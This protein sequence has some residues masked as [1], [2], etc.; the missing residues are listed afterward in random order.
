MINGILP[1]RRWNSTYGVVREMGE[2]Q[3]MKPMVNELRALIKNRKL[4]EFIN[5]VKDLRESELLKD[6]GLKALYGLYLFFIQNH[7]KAAEILNELKDKEL[8][9]YTLA[10]L[11]LL[12]FFVGDYKLSKSLLH[13]ALKTKEVD[14]ATWARLANISYIEKDFDKAEYYW[15]RSLEINPDKLEVLYNLGVLKLNK[16]DFSEALNYFN[17]VLDRNP[18]YEEAEEK[19]TAALLNLNRIELIIDEYY[20]K[21]E[22]DKSEQN[23][24]KLGKVLHIAGRY[25]EARAVLIEAISKYKCDYRLKLLLVDVLEAEGAIGRAGNLLKEWVETQD[26]CDWDENVKATFRF[27]LNE[28]RVKAGFLDTAEQDIE[29]MKSKEDYPEYYLIKSDIL[30]E[31]NKGIEAKEILEKALEKF[32]AHLEILSKL[33]HILTSIGELDRAKDIQEQIVAI[34]PA[35]LVRQVEMN[36]YKATDEQIAILENMIYSKTLPKDSR[37]SAG[38]VLHTVLEKRKEYDK[39]FEVLIKANELVKED[40]DYN[41]KEHRFM[42]ERTI[43]VFTPDL[44]KKLYGKGH[45]SNRP[46]FV[47]GMPRSG[48]TLAEQILGSHSS[49][50]PAGELPFVGKIVSLMPKVVKSKRGWPDAML[51][52]DENLLKSAGQYYL[53]KIENLDNKHTRVVDKLPHNFDYIGLILLMFPN[54]KVIHLNRNDLDVAVSNFQQNFAAKHGTMG[55]AFDLKW[56]GHML[57]DHKRI[58]EHWRSL[59]G[60]KIFELD[61]QKLTE[62]PE[63]TIRELLDF[64]ELPWED[65]VLEFYTTKRPV[66]TASIKQVRQKIYRSSVE[67]WRRYEKYLQP[68]IKILEEGFKSLES[69]DT[70]KFEDAVK[71]MGFFGITRC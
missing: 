4:D 30:M 42:I 24:F 38:F 64:C 63:N 9:G 23:Y 54:A 44:V 31:R 27:K 62:D 65:R 66:K 25:P 60:E 69:G 19:K 67:K 50:Y 18:D 20:S 49:V 46:I 3:G 12:A 22:K 59:F 21:I 6:Y 1:P 16:G 52:M 5:K 35:A 8:D 68:V 53:S 45:P 57:N 58:M 40:I 56:I 39:A 41:W 7:E 17:M 37:A 2:S 47:L 28:F 51:D 33:V 61:Y 10:D 48:T 15:Q 36:D 34:N 26:E 55:F 13:K 43:Q 11:G 14:E 29:L 32:P 70:V 71:P